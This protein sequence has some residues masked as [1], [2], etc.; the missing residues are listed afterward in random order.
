[1]S[2]KKNSRLLFN[3]K[4]GVYLKNNE[5]QKIFG[6]NLKLLFPLSYKENL[7][8]TLLHSSFYDFFYGKEGV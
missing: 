1:M 2:T 4:P 5:F 7:K 8:T 3:L 6:E